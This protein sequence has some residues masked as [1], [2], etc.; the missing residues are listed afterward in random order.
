MVKAICTDPGAFFIESLSRAAWT[1]K[2][3]QGEECHEFRGVILNQ[4]FKPNN[5]GLKKKKNLKTSQ[6]PLL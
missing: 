2:L 5:S 6:S 3:V 1:L 4:N